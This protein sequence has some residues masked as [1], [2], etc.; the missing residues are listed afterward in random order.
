M[1]ESLRAYLRP[2]FILCK[3]LCLWP[4]NFSGSE[5]YAIIWGLPV[6]IFILYSFYENRKHQD[7]FYA[8]VTG[9]NQ[10]EDQLFIHCCY[11]GLL[12]LI[13]HNFIIRK[14]LKKSFERLEYFD[15]NN[16]YDYRK[17]RNLK[18]DLFLLII[19]ILVL[20]I[21]DN[22]LCVL[23]IRHYSVLYY[24]G[25]MGSPFMN[26]VYVLVIY[27]V[28]YITKNMFNKINS[29]LLSVNDNAFNCDTIK[30][31]ARYHHELS[32]FVIQQNNM[33]ALPIVEFVTQSLFILVWLVYYPTTII[34]NLIYLKESNWLALDNLVLLLLHFLILLLMC[35]SW[36][37][38]EK[39]VSFI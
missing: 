24:W 30:R 8:G 18:K 4:I 3:I 9:A 2:I 7:I 32:S 11:Y 19:S 27:E 20:T 17:R 6:Q 39:E 5:K 15:K 12:I 33:F 16:I 29:D 36:V 1:S 26:I 22:L 37:S 31:L 28:L 38:I 25:Y 23:F 13:V 14:K 10:F 34:F 35:Y 21:V